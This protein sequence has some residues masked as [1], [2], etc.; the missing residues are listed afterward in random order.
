ME[1]YIIHSDS[2]ERTEKTVGFSAAQFAPHIHKR[3]LS[4]E[5]GRTSCKY[6]GLSGTLVYLV[7][8]KEVVKICLNLR[9]GHHYSKNPFSQRET[10]HSHGFWQPTSAAN[11]KVAQKFIRINTLQRDK[12]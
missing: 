10:T 2:R 7:S 11:R 6:C 9:H 3:V 8:S 4:H 5:H 12:V 1:A